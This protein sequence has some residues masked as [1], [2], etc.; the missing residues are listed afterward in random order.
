MALVQLQIRTGADI[1]PDYAQMVDEDIL[2]GQINGEALD[3][4]LPEDLL[5]R[6]PEEGSPASRM[7]ALIEHSGKAQLR[8]RLIDHFFALGEAGRPMAEAAWRA[9]GLDYGR[10]ADLALALQGLLAQADERMR[11]NDVGAAHGRF[12]ITDARCRLA[13][14]GLP[15]WQGRY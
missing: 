6:L 4:F 7:G 15:P 9:T 13:V 12:V 3:T 8:R 1:T 10:R 5:A 14:K 2:Q 11:R